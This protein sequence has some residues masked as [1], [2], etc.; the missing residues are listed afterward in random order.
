[1]IL[2]EL[3][4]LAPDE[5]LPVIICYLRRNP[6]SAH[7]VVPNEV[8]EFFFSYLFEDLRF[9]LFGEIVSHKQNESSLTWFRW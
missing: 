1:M 2:K 4:Y 8:D 9:H 6:E 7:D 5:L 3:C